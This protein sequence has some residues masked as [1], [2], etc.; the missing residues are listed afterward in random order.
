LC[1][2]FLIPWLLISVVLLVLCWP[3]LVDLPLMLIAAI[4]MIIGFPVLFTCVES[5]TEGSIDGRK[6]VLG[7]LID[8]SDMFAS[9]HHQNEI[10]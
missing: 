3:A 9:L 10:G 5:T 6:S 8:P 2:Q 4:L 7:L 1:P